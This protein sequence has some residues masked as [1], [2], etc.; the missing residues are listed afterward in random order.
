MLN[1][2]GSTEYTSV[3]MIWDLFGDDTNNNIQT[4][5]APYPLPLLCTSI[6]DGHKW[7]YM[8]IKAA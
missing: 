5:I 8:V 2:V 1:N 7:S 3:C 6:V 4:T